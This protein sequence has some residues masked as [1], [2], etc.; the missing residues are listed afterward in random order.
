MKIQWLTI[1]GMVLLESSIFG[2]SCGFLLKR[3]K[4]QS[5]VILILCKKIFH[6]GLRAYCVKPALKLKNQVHCGVGLSWM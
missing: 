2:V 1:P 4:R 5:V 3:L 6:A